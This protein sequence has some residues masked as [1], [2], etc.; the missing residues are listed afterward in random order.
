MSLRLLIVSP[1]PSYPQDQGNSARIHLLGQGLRQAGIIVHFLYAQMEGLT[2]AQCAAM[3][4]DWDYFHPM[5]YAPCD[6]RATGAGVYCLDDWYDPAVTR[7]ATELHRR[8]HFHAVLAN[9]VWFSRVLAAFPSGVLKILDTHDVFGGRDQRFRDA[10][11]TPEW[12]YTSHAEEA[13]G[14]RRADIV[15]AIQDEEAAWFRATGH[16]DVR[17]IGHAPAQRQRAPGAPSG[18]VRVGY[19]ASGNP[20]NR[21]SLHDLATR[22]PKDGVAGL[23]FVVAGSIC[24]GL[25]EQPGPFEIL[26]RVAALDDFYDQVDLVVNP[27]RFGTGLKI[28]SVEAIFEGLPLIATRPA[29]VGLPA[30]HPFHDLPDPDAVANCLTETRFDQAMLATLAEASRSSARDYRASVRAGIRGL[31]EAIHGVAAAAEAA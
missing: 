22:L 16:N 28:K 4:E 7:V 17:V 8:W 18:A 13:R 3:Q 12:F 2:P 19:I 30:R 27:M 11:L 14:L 26:G 9:Y 6:M 15:L 21:R 20:L 31:G 29:M 10:G 1:I 23:R 24:G 5:P 25:A